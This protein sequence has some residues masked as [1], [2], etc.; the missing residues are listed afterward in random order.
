MALGALGAAV[1]LA[2]SAMKAKQRAGPLTR[3]SRAGAIFSEALFWA[4]SFALLGSI[5]AALYLL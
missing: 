1:L 4:V 3:R 2:H 5:I